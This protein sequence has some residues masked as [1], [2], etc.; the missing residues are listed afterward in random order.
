MVILFLVWYIYLYYLSA[1]CSNLIY[2]RTFLRHNFTIHSIALLVS[3]VYM[4]KQ[5]VSITKAWYLILGG[6]SQ[7]GPHVWCEISNLI[8]LRHSI[9]SKEVAKLSSFL[10]IR[11]FFTRAPHVLIYNLMK[12]TWTP[13][14]FTLWD[15]KH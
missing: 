11:I 4:E 5:V 15:A 3:A 13:D 14:I 7:I 12:L 9:R 1:A 8:C 2:L 6:I 10:K